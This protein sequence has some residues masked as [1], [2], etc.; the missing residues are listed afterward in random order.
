[1]C[2][3][4]VFHFFQKIRTVRKP[5]MMFAV[6]G[7]VV[8]VVGRVVVVVAFVFA[9]GI[10]L[11]VIG[12]VVFVKAVFSCSKTNRTLLWNCRACVRWANAFSAF[13]RVARFDATHTSTTGIFDRIVKVIAKDLI[14]LRTGF[15]F[16][17]IAYVTV[18]IVGHAH[19]THSVLTQ[20]CR[21]GAVAFTDAACSCARIENAAVCFVTILAG[22]WIIGQGLCAVGHGTTFLF[23]C[24]ASIGA[25]GNLAVGRPSAASTETRVHSVVSILATIGRRHTLAAFAAPS[26]AWD[27]LSA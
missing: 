20:R 2:L 25:L 22:V 10:G 11:V 14:R 27:D 23:R 5:E 21:A 8:V 26:R 12:L 6:V 19:F 3:P 16:A 15:V 4:D 9:V 7:R 18:V 24:N 1:M 17:S 13:G